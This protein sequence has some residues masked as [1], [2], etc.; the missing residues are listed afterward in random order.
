MAYRIL[1]QAERLAGFY[2]CDAMPVGVVRELEVKMQHAMGD[3]ESSCTRG[4]ISGNKSGHADMRRQE[5]HRALREKRKTVGA[6]G[7]TRKGG[8]SIG[9]GRLAGLFVRDGR[10]SC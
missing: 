4:A 7:H 1:E 6:V 5:G 8:L 2:W 9:P 3:K 10:P